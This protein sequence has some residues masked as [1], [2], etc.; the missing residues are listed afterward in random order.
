M[1]FFYKPGPMPW[2]PG[3]YSYMNFLPYMDPYHPVPYNKA[4]ACPPPMPIPPMPPLP[5]VAGLPDNTVGT[6]QL[7][8]S[9]VTLDK[10]SPEVREKLDALK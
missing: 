6:G 3:W 10:L 7:Q 9:A 5:P 8:D 4:P 1:P 2:Y